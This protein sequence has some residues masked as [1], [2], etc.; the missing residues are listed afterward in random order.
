MQMHDADNNNPIPVNTVEHTVGKP[1]EHGTSNGPVNDLVLQRI[2]G[3]P[4]ERRIHR[5]DE[6]SSESRSL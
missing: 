1:M 2:V 6:L 3:N 4:G 5:S